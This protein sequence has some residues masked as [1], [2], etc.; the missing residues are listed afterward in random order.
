MRE[1]QSADSAMNALYVW[2]PRQAAMK[3][4]LS[5]LSRAAVKGLI[6]DAECID[7]AI[8]GV[9]RTNPWMEFE[10]LVARFAG[11]KLGRAA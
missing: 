8:K 6:M 11:A 10:A 1:G 9:V 3:Q 7:R 5:R 4:A 2:R